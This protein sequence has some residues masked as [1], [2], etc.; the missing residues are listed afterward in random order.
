MDRK[1]ITKHEN[2]D[3]YIKDAARA[4]RQ[5]DGKTGIILAFLL[6]LVAIVL[7]V[8]TDTIFYGAVVFGIIYIIS[9]AAYTKR[10]LRANKKLTDTKKADNIV[11]DEEHILFTLDGEEVRPPLDYATVKTVIETD[12]QY[13]IFAKPE[14]NN[15]KKEYVTVQKSGIESSESYDFKRFLEEKTGKPIER[16]KVTDKNAVLTAV[17]MI[18]VLAAALAGSLLFQMSDRTIEVETLSIKLPR[19]FE[20]RDEK[21]N[22]T[23]YEYWFDSTHMSVGILVDELELDNMDLTA[24]EIYK[25]CYTDEDPVIDSAEMTVLDDNRIRFEYEDE[26]DGDKYYIV[27]EFGVYG[28]TYY[29]TTIITDSSD[30]TDKAIKYLD[31]VKVNSEA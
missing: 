19:S 12:S 26:A 9:Y 16:L 4:G 7:S 1:F 27:E 5:C 11:F 25:I 13:V 30:Y 31:T 18:V 15:G 22:M 29:W 2:S 3:E 20:K 28:N 8:F 6:S 21:D 17:V 14:A 24:E 23:D 10:A